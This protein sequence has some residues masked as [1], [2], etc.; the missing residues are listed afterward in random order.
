MKPIISLS[1]TQLL[2]MWLGLLLLVL[3]AG[4]A[5]GEPP[6]SI[7]PIPEHVKVEV[8]RKVDSGEYPSL[9]VGAYE[10]GKGEDYYVYGWQV[11]KL[12]TKHDKSA[13][14]V[15]QPCLF[16]RFLCSLSMGGKVPFKN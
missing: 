14:P 16:L 15:L 8:R 5:R 11:R 4:L 1:T 3:S 13:F 12:H 10:E 6:S 7:V 9:A 2:A